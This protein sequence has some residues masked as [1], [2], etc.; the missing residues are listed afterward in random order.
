[1]FFVFVLC[2]HE[3]EYQFLS[4]TM[5]IYV[6]VAVMEGVDT[7][8]MSKVRRHTQTADGGRR[9]ERSIYMHVC[10]VVLLSV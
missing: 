9:E 3:Q 1:M 7:S 8:L 10:V 2:C 4:G 5:I 6:S